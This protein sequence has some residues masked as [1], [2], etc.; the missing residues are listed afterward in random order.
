MKLLTYYRCRSP[1][2]MAERVGAPSNDC[3]ESAW[4]NTGAFARRKYLHG[5]KLNGEVIVW[6][7]MQATLN[8]DARKCGQANGKVG[9]A[10]PRYQDGSLFIRGKRIKV[11]VARW[12]EDVIREDGTLHRT[13]PTVVLGLLSD[14]SRR[15]ARSLLQKRVSE[16]NR[17]GHRTRMMMTL[18]TFSSHY[19]EPGALLALKPSSSRIYKFNLD[20]YILPALGSH[21]LCDVNRAAIEQLFISMRDKGYA[22]STLH[23]IRVTIAKVL[24]TAVDNSYLERNPAHGIKIGERESNKHRTYLEPSQVQL[25]TPALSEPCRTIVKTAVLTGMR[26]GEILGL[27]WSRVDFSRGTINVSET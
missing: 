16:I 1:G 19:C 18:S 12:R 14:L 20:K 24:Q 21:R 27:R 7:D 8:H 5:L 22:T 6:L 3:L 9:M 10:R 26:I 13:Q 17:G 25:L 4:G 11:W 15:E 2:Y 23:S